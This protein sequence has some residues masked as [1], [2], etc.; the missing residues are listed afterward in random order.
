[1][2]EELSKE[3][4]WAEENDRRNQI[5]AA[6]A[7]QVAGESRTY[8]DAVDDYLRMVA[9]HDQAVKVLM[10][11]QKVHAMATAKPHFDQQE[12]SAL[13]AE[14]GSMYHLL[15][16]F[17]KDQD[18]ATILDPEEHKDQIRAM[19]RVQRSGIASSTFEPEVFWGTYE[20]VALLEMKAR[21]QRFLAFKAFTEVQRPWLPAA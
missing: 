11:G 1:L 12:W 19:E 13:G 6:R 18:P 14:A 10:Q 16:G 15:Q 5:A 8:A 20:N 17:L 4:G 2:E 9:V 7:A 3:E 21:E